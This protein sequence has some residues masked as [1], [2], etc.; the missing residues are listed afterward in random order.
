MANTEKEQI[1][2]NRE[3]HEHTRRLKKS[4]NKI[5][6]SHAL[7]QIFWTAGPVTTLGLIGGYYIGYGTT[8]SLQLLIYFVSFTVFSGIIG[9]IAKVVYD[10]TRGHLEEQSERDILAVTDKLGDLILVARDKIVQEY[11]GEYRQREAALQLLKRVDLTPYGVTIAFT[12]L[13]DN[14]EIGEIMGRI[15][16]YRR[17]GL[18]TKV[19]DLYAS[20]RKQID[21]VAIEL[22]KKSPEAA[23]ELKIWFSGNLSGRLK[24]GVRREK[25]FLQRVMSAIENDN[26]Y[27][28][29]FRDVEEMMILGFELI[30]GRE[31]PTLIFSYPGNWKYASA[32]DEVEKK[33]SLYRVAQ[34]RGGNRIRALAAYLSESDFVDSE[35]IPEGLKIN[36]LIKKVTQVI[37]RLTKKVKTPVEKGVVSNKKRKQLAALLENSV[38]LY[39]MAY[40]GYKESA[41][42]YKELI[43]AQKKWGRMISSGEGKTAKIKVGS[44]KKGIRINENV[45]SLNEQSRL[46]V[47]RHLKWYFEKENTGKNN[48]FLLS[49]FYSQSGMS[50]R[51]LAIEIATALEPHIRISKPEIQRNINATK[52]IYLGGLSPDMSAVQKQEFGK[53]KSSEV[54]NG[55]E[56]AALRLADTLV[57]QYH[58]E[59]SDE[60]IEFLHYNYNAKLKLL[61]KVARRKKSLHP[62]SRDI[63]EIP[64]SMIRPKTE[65]KKSI[66]NVLKTES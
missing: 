46:L 10:G 9:L 59:L 28:M 49:S 7:M 34:A 61:E 8:P 23:K 66:Q 47:C 38:E 41:K 25:H 45:I 33:R 52:A 13:T 35:E 50:A 36:D 63:Q 51:R 24:Y 62:M 48:H 39:E 16:A 37:D 43:Q 60:A 2:L 20:Y 14:Q 3:S 64:P 18:Q 21:D 44:G 32:L 55:L 54:D 57:H 6:W 15:F 40:E 4:L 31:I 27:I 19:H 5:K 30:C 56:L 65:W 11:E 42:R 12:D 22:E 26:P 58:A 1:K 17:I 29:T 53:Q